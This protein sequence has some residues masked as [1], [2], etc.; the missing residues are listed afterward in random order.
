ML[1]ILT[2]KLSID[3]IMSVLLDILLT[4]S[5]A[6]IQQSAWLLKTSERENIC[7]VQFTLK[8]INIYSVSVCVSNTLDCVALLQYVVLLYS[9]VPFM[10]L[11]TSRSC[12]ASLAPRPAV[13]SWRPPLGGLA[14]SDL[15]HEDV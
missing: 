9:L 12:L 7:K 10:F 3:N 13:A 15:Q 1:S 6:P 11:L 5:K 8:V 4:P 14:T 2:I